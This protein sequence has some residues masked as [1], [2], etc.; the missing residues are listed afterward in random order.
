MPAL[1]QAETPQVEME[2]AVAITRQLKELNANP[3]MFAVTAGSN[4]PQ[5]L[6]NPRDGVR[7]SSTDPRMRLNRF[8]LGS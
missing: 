8:A 2:D 4:L 7:S 1:D 6:R 3:R 5:F